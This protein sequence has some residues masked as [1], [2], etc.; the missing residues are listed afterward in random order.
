VVL[1]HVGVHELH[2]IGAKRGR[3]DGRERRFSRLVTRQGKDAYKRTS[4]GHDDD[5][6]VIVSSAQQ[7]KRQ[8]QRASKQL[9][10]SEYRR[11]LPQILE[12]AVKGFTRG[13]E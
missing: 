12:Q 8:R 7:K 13:K 2:N 1:V 3:H 6:L 4:G 5:E 10:R 9:V 11:R